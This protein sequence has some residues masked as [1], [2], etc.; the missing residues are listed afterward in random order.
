MGKKI[1]LILIFIFASV[2]V[3]AQ[4]GKNKVQYK[5]YT[6]F[7]IQTKHFDI[8]FPQGGE[9]LAEF[10]AGAIED[11]LQS[12]QRTLNYTIN[13]RISF[14][15][16]KSTNDFQETNVTDEYL[17]EGI[18]GFTELFKNRIVLPFDGNYSHFRHVI[19]HE[20][21]HSVVNDMFY[22]GSIQNVI[23]K[24]ISIQLPLW[25]NEGLAEYE[26][27]GW[28]TDEDMFIRDAVINDYLPDINNL[29]GY[30]AYR[31]GQSVFYYIEKKYGKEKIGEIVNKTKGQGSLEE[32][33]K[34][35][36]GLNIEE[37]NERWKKDLKKNYWPDIA[38]HDDPDVFA[39]RLTNHK[40]EGGTY[41][42]SPAISPQG[43]K[44]AFISNRNFFFDVYIMNVIDGK[45]VKKLIEGNRSEEFEQLNILTPGLSW[46][47]DGKKI[48]ISAKS[49]GWDVIYIID[50]ESEDKEELPVRM[51]GISSVTWSPDGKYLAFVGHNGSQSDIFMY[52]LWN[53]ELTN[54]TDDIFS[55]L[56]PVWAPDSKSI[57]FA[58]DRN[59]YFD[60]K[61]LPDSFRI[62]E[63]NFKNTDLYNIN[64]D[65]R[66]ISRIT[67]IPNGDE[68]SPVVSSDGKEILF[69]SS[70][71][72]INNIYKQRL[73]L[74]DKDTVK[75][76]YQL[77]PIPITNSLNGLY[78]LSLSEDGKK[79]VFSTL[80]E[81]AY[82]IFLLNNPFEPKTDLKKLVPTVYYS[83]LLLPGDHKID[84]KQSVKNNIDS[85]NA[86]SANNPSIFV[87]KV[88]ENVKADTTR[89]MDFSRYVF[90]GPKF[91]RKDTTAQ[92]VKSEFNL[93]DNLDANGNYIV[94]KYK[95]NFSPDI[96]YANAGYSTLYGL[97]GT[98]VL[99]FSD[100]LGNH[101]IIGV[102]SLQIDLKNSDYGLAYYYLPNRLDLGVEGFHTARFVYLQRGLYSYLYRF[103]NYGLVT[104]ASYPLNKFYRLDGGISWLNVSSDNLDDPTEPSQ[105]V[106]YLIPSLSFV[107]DNV[108]WG[109]TSPIEGTRYNFT[110]F[111][112][113]ISG[114]E[115]L[116][117]Y[118]LNADY[119]EYFRF[120]YDNSFVFRISG[121]FSG[122]ENPQRFFIGGTD[123]WINRHFKTGD[124]PIS[125]A[126]DFAFLTPALPLR[127]YDYAEQIGSKYALLN[128]ELRMPLIRYLVTGPLPILFQNILGVAFIDAGSAWDNTDKLQFIAKQNGKTMTKD[129]LIGSGFGARMFFLYFLLR[130]DVAW[131]YNLDTFSQPKYYFSIGADF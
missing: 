111:G 99:S 108:L 113:P 8:Y 89:K 16:Y 117:F 32:G 13:N 98:T 92:N 114:S 88:E 78:Q 67:D 52:N 86:G 65:T 1:F 69:I 68:I 84:H 95:I 53:K 107:H 129:L 115:K 59:N 17:E 81:S 39:K 120:W 36:I 35:S 96:I 94:H 28:N 7:Y 102:T 11:A 4:F 85:T 38:I 33:L 34:A 29:D 19:H 127:G 22:G 3:F 101:R 15:I 97:L 131:A 61:T 46:S 124:I 123:N 56:D 90:N 25:F 87:G 45:I 122:G 18:G 110:L 47:P 55:D 75:N 83:N 106:S 41:N 31:G 60:S 64:I 71:N 103:R 116:S 70:Y 50:V 125:N 62:S 104:S 119:R 77:K 63:Y 118:S 126:S 73:Y 49:K 44:V 48:V 91:Y 23:S 58:S 82:N 76:I 54:L 30:L 109:Y 14:I 74:T 9:K 93:T 51:D 27:L 24:G 130:L 43:D 5:N 10:S 57:Y 20:L 12:V 79:L 6:W 26:S 128:L 80:Y 100:M 21:T 37:L 2:Q 66:E 72:G 121:G 40:K 42:T 112:N 105:K